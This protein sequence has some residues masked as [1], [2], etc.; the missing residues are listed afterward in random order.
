[1]FSFCCERW[2][3]GPVERRHYLQQWSKHLHQHHLS[4]TTLEFCVPQ[5]CTLFFMKCLLS[6]CGSCMV[7]TWACAEWCS[8]FIMKLHKSWSGLL[9]LLTS[10]KIS[11]SVQALNMMEWE[12]LWVNSIHQP[13]V[14]LNCSSWWIIHDMCYTFF[15][16]FF[17]AVGFMPFPNGDWL[18]DNDAITWKRLWCVPIKVANAAVVLVDLAL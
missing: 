9:F 5:T 4:N 15:F 3:T 13:S 2:C 18:R 8:V 10:R 17:A 14:L 11:P 12:R 1:M 6:F 7:S 16:L